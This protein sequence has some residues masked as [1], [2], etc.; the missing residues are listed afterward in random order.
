MTVAVDAM[1]AATAPYA[2]MSIT[3]QCVAAAIVKNRGKHDVHVILRGGSKGT[4]YD[5]DSVQAVAA[6]VK[7]ARLNGY[8]SIMVDCSR[9]SYSLFFLISASPV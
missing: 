4:N 1:R 8:P 6:A 9:A 3:E 2:F 5:A 7:K